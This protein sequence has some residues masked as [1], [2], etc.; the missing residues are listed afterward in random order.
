MFLEEGNSN[1][2]N[3]RRAISSQLFPAVIRAVYALSWLTMMD[4]NTKIIIDCVKDKLVAFGICGVGCSANALGY[5][6]I[7]ARGMYQVGDTSYLFIA[8][9]PY[10]DRDILILRGRCSDETFLGILMCLEMMSE[11]EVTCEELSSY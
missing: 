4:T 7:L 10:L 9:S 3:T 11:C 8:K 6:T 5:L 1:K 2:L